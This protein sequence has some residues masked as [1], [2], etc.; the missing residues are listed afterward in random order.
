MQL[1]PHTNEKHLSHYGKLLFAT[2]Y[3]SMAAMFLAPKTLDN[4]M[5]RFGDRFVYV[6]A[7]SPKE[8]KQQDTGGT[9]YELPN[10]Q[11]STYSDL[12]MPG[13]EYV[14]KD[15]VVPIKKYR[16]ESALAAMKENKVEVYFVDES[17]LR[18]IRS[19]DDHGLIILKS[20]ASHI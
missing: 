3:K 1:D 14:T 10:A 16:Y 4:E 6:A 17:T 19:A 2:P 7:T 9:I 11:F 8:F 15:P 18:A 12:N 13:T 20:L 5:M